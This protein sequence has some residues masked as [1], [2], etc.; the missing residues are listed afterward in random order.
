MIKIKKINYKIL[1]PDKKTYTK[2]ASYIYHLRYHHP[3]NVDTTAD[4]QEA[5]PCGTCGKVFNSKLRLDQHDRGHKRA[6]KLRNK[7]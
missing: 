3:D 7:R 6:E 2:R 1:L 5:F 4:V